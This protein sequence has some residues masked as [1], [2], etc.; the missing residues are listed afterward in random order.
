MSKIQAVIFDADGTLFDTRTLIYDAY[1]HVATTHH[2]ENPPQEAVWALMGRPIP[3]I[4]QR[5]FP[6]GDIPAMVATNNT[7]FS[8]RS[9]FVKGFD[10]LE[11]LLAHLC[12]KGILLGVLTSGDDKIFQL[13]EH[14]R[15]ADY[16]SVVVHADMLQ[17]HKPDPEGY[18][19]VL[20][21]MQIKPEDSIMVGD[22]PPD[23]GVA[24][25]AAAH[26]SVAV[27]HGF[28]SREQLAEAGADYIIDSLFEL[29]NVLEQIEHDT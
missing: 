17:S 1:C 27:T 23:V 9:V 22:L 7:F 21:K 5:L 3:E 8:E 14:N 29:E 24:K 6:G 4:L 13:L 28:G 19:R 2:F 15:V 10:G 18:F 20:E 26:A 11:D 12:E 16:F 25:N